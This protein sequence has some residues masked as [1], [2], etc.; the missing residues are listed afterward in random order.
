MKSTRRQFIHTTIATGVALEGS[1]RLAHGAAG[2]PHA[3]EEVSRLISKEGK[4]DGLTKE[5]IP[6]PALILDLDIFESNLQKMAAHARAQG[7]NLRPHAKTH[8]CAQVARR[9]KELGAVGSCV[10]TVPEAEVMV[11]GG[12]GRVHLTSPI[13]DPNKISRMVRLAGRDPDLM[14]AVDHARQGEMFQEAASAAGR[15]LNVLVDLNVGDRRTGILPGQ[16]ALELARM[17]DRAK[18]LKLRGVQAYSGGSSHVV[19]FEA[20]SKHSLGRM[21]QAAETWLRL[22]KEGLPAEIFSGGST[23][24]YNID[25]DLAE[26]TELQAGSYVFMDLDYRRIGGQ[27]GDV[28]GDFGNSLTVLASVVSTNHADRVTLDAGLK[29][30][31]TDRDFGPEPKDVSGVSYGWGGDEFG[32]LTLTSPSR[33]LRLG[34]RLEL[35][36]PH[37]DPSVNLYDR[38]HACRGDQVEE[39]WSVMDRLGG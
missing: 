20:R 13:S 33:P 37:C 29:A 15:A 11:A 17:V 18:N 5:N 2:L 9:Q 4:I 24:T 25:T 31:S 38:I 8:K 22:Q 6:T 3:G 12:I 23:G 27:Q 35:I 19:G 39:I 32:I 7:K 10:A 21:Q 34:D 30:F 28:Y 36:I 14:V 1:G 16:P 26:L